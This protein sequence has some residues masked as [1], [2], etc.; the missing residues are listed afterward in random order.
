MGGASIWPYLIQVIG[1]FREEWNVNPV[2]R[3]D[4]LGSST[5]ELACRCSFNP[6]PQGLVAD[7]QLLA[8][9]PW[10]QPFLDA[11]DCQFLELGC[12][13]GVSSRNGKN[14]T[15]AEYKWSGGCRKLSQHGPTIEC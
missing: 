10:C 8:Y 5:V 13:F 7:P 15:L 1:G 4:Y 9:R 14:R 11:L 2:L 3:C 6:V 12:V